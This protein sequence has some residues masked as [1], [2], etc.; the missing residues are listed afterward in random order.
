[1]RSAKL[2]KKNINF[3]DKKNMIVVNQEKQ[4]QEEIAFY[5]NLLN[6]KFPW[7]PIKPVAGQVEAGAEEVIGKSLALRILEI[8]V[9]E[10]IREATKK[11]FKV[12]AESLKLFESNIADEDVH[13][14]QLQLAY[15]AYK[16]TS[17]TH[18]REAEEIKSQWLDC[19]DHPMLKAMILERSI[20][21]ILL[22]MMRMFGD[23][24][25]R[26]ISADISRK[27]IAA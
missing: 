9:G 8:Y 4:N 3:K 14:R 26:T 27:C 16:I 19:K 15:D 25:L 10:F 17:S 18:Q 24:A 7:T 5:S 11:E 6:R 2:R 22:P 20:F 1:M 13:D 23:T 21:F 12:P